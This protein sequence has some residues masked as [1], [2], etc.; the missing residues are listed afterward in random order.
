LGATLA[1]ALR[2]QGFLRLR[3]FAEFVP[4]DLPT[5]MH[6][7]LIERSLSGRVVG[8]IVRDATEIEVRDKPIKKQ[9]NDKKDEPPPDGARPTR[10]L[11]RLCED[12][13]RPKPEPTQL[14]RQTTQNLD[15][16]RADLPTACDA[17][18]KKNGKGCEETGSAKNYI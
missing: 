5:K 10:E 17:G 11:G 1:S 8:A 7:A 6:A 18:S 2:S 9:P 14:K 12:E 4:G 13:E 16:M 3:A 15:Q